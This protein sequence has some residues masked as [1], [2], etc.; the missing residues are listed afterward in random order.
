MAARGPSAE[1]RDGGARWV[2]TSSRMR[3]DVTSS[4]GR[5]GVTSSRGRVARSLVCVGTERHGV[6]GET[7]SQ[8]R[9]SDERGHTRTRARLDRDAFVW[10]QGGDVTAGSGRACN[11][12]GRGDMTRRRFARE[13]REPIGSRRLVRDG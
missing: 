12:A 13:N 3:S 2:V 4:R 6:C 8:C 5:S 10:D 1:S 7:R 11:V 9:G